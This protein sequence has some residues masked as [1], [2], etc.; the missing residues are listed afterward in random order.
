MTVKDSRSA[1]K[2]LWAVLAGAFVLIA[3]A[4]ILGKPAPT[5]GLRQLQRQHL[6]AADNR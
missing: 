4:A 2:Y 6:V 5:A 1:R 3:L